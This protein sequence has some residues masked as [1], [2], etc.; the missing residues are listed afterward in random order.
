MNLLEIE[1]L[2]QDLVALNERIGEMEQKQGRQI[3]KPK[4]Q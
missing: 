3:L 1:V 4:K 2:R